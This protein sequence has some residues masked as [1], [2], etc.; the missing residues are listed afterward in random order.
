MLIDNNIWPRGVYLTFSVTKWYH[1]YGRFI[2]SE[3]IFWAIILLPWASEMLFYNWHHSE[4]FSISIGIDEKMTISIK[5]NGPQW[6]AVSRKD[7]EKKCNLTLAVGP[8]VI[9][10]TTSQTEGRTKCRS[11]SRKAVS[12]GCEQPLRQLI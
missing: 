4:L 7:Y 11:Y 1:Q 5:N 6:T 9:W 2:N 10:R 3:A 8:K 12:Q